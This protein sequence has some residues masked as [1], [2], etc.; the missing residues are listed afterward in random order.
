M[1]TRVAPSSCRLLLLKLILKLLIIWKI[2]YDFGQIFCQVYQ[3]YNLCKS[4][5]VLT[6]SVISGLKSDGDKHSA[7]IDSC[8]LCRIKM[9]CLSWTL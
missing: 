4:N 3:I 7:Y 5:L 2:W 9:Y 6:N 1:F 8:Y